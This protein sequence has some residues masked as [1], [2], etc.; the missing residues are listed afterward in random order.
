MEEFNKIVSTQISTTNS[1]IFANLVNV[2]ITYSMSAT[3]SQVWSATN[4]L[5]LLSHIALI[6]L[7]KYPSCTINM[8]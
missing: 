5:Q 8:F 6:D 1:F 4:T 3:M 2:A 7:V